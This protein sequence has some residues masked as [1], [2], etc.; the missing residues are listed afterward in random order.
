MGQWN[1]SPKYPRRSSAPARQA[2]SRSKRP[3][4]TRAAPRAWVSPV[5]SRQRRRE[6]ITA[7]PVAARSAR[8]LGDAPR[9]AR[10]LDAHGGAAVLS[11]DHFGTEP[12]SLGVVG[13]GGGD[14]GE[15]GPEA[16]EL[17]I[18]PVRRKDARID[19][20]EHRIAHPIAPREVPELPR[21]A[22]GAPVPSHR[23]HGQIGRA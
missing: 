15:G 18:A 19:G 7:G 4:T 11:H 1:A 13:E 23:D 5:S 10:E 12:A 14:G 9:V 22:A 3:R 2:A 21:R 20:P 6:S 16:R 8:S 17:R